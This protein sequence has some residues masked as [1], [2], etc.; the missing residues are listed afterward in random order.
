MTNGVS[1]RDAE[2]AGRAEADFRIRGADRRNQEQP[3]RQHQPA[4][5][6]QP[7]RRP[8]GR[9]G[10][11]HAPSSAQDTIQPESELPAISSRWRA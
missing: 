7:R 9:R 6:A 2:R 5:P 1:A 4:A 8:P 10:A 11:D 3:R